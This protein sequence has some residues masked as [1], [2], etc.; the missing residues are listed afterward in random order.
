M[1]NLSGMPRNFS[2]PNFNNMG[3]QQP[4]R[5]S[6]PNQASSNLLGDFASLSQNKTGVRLFLI[7]YCVYSF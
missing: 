1:A 6:A 7:V 3:F 4:A 5:F 2:A